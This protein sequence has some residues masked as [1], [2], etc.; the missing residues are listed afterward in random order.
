MNSQP[1]KKIQLEKFKNILL[2]SLKIPVKIAYQSINSIIVLLFINI[3]SAGWLAFFVWH[4]LNVNIVWTLILTLIICFPSYT[5]KN[6]YATL[7]EVIGLPEKIVTIFQTGKVKVTELS[8]AHDKVLANSQEKLGQA[9]SKSSFGKSIGFIFA[10]GKRLR[11]W[12][13]L[14]QQLREFKSL[15]NESQELLALTAQAMLL[16]NPLFLFWVTIATVLTFVWAFVAF[17]TLIIYCFAR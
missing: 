13:L 4:K 5:L 14:A 15:M 12:F 10:I 16:T 17:V 7:K 9:S 11:D 3:I 8:Q 6:L 2:E 1:D